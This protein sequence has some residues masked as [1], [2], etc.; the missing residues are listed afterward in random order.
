MG[1]ASSMVVVFFAIIL[2]IS[3]I[4]IRVRRGLWI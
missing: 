3:L 4:V 2:G 1:M